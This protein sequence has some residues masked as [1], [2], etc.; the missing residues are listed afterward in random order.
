MASKGVTSRKG[1]VTPAQPARITK[2]APHDSLTVAPAV[3]AGK[4]AT[5]TEVARWVARNIDNPAASPKDC[6]DSF[7]WT[8]LRMCREDPAFALMFVKD[9]W[10]K[11]LA[12]QARQGEEATGGKIDGTPTLELIQRIRLVRDGG[13]SGVAQLEACR[14]HTPKVDGSSPSPASSDSFDQ[15][16]GGE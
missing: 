2:E 9:I 11:L 1:N 16:K 10:T 5:E 14:T 13:N 4:T 15:F 12:S 6:P 3:L 7:A 8:L